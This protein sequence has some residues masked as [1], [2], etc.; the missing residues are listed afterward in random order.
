MAPWRKNR[1]DKRGAEPPGTEPGQTER[2]GPSNRCRSRPPWPAQ[3]TWGV[4]QQC[5][6][7]DPPLLQPRRQAARQLPVLLHLH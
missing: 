2:Q 5:L 4:Q 3:P 6:E 7:A 1:L